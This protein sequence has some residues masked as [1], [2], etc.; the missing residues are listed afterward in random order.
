V[1]FTAYS[2]DEDLILQVWNAGDPI[3][4]ESI[5]KIFEP[6]WRHSVS[7]SRNG[8]GLGLHICSQIV[9]A[10]E[11]HISVTSTAAHG[12]LFTARL[13]LGTLPILE[14]SRIEILAE[15]ELQQ[16]PPTIHP[17]IYA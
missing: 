7:G 1:K 9:R 14:Q 10:H 5:N 6:F 11:G 17:A 16:N 13:P 8:L 3:P 12:T 4:P 15:G 2:D